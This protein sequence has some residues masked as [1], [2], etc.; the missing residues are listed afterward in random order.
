MLAVDIDDIV[1]WFMILRSTPTA[2]FRASS[3]ARSCKAW[4]TEAYQPRMKESGKVNKLKDY[5][6]PMWC[7][8]WSPIWR[9]LSA[10]LGEQGCAP[11][12]QSVSLSLLGAAASVSH[13]GATTATPKQDP[14]L[15]SCLEPNCFIPKHCETGNWK[16]MEKANCW[17]RSKVSY[18]DSTECLSV[19]IRLNMAKRTIKTERLPGA[20]KLG[21]G[22]FSSQHSHDFTCHNDQVASAAWQPY[23]G[24]RPARCRAFQCQNGYLRKPVSTFRTVD[25][26]YS[27][28]L[29]PIP[30][31]NQ[32]Y[33][34]WMFMIA[35]SSQ[36]SLSAVLFQPA[37]LLRRENSLNDKVPHAANT[38]LPK[39]T[40]TTR[41]SKGHRTRWFG[42]HTIPV[43][44]LKMRQ[45]WSK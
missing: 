2:L 8:S 9:I 45:I 23:C 39:C 38:P 32:L 13:N 16:K 24:K 34:L 29:E 21:H 5:E 41:G 35:C 28:F 33:S 18:E 31:L 26:L 27:F 36:S 37:F 7:F 20:G 17:K 14:S 22:S 1:Y 11:L 6:H 40:S 12:A 43:R 4:A 3:L 30:T 44:P 15:S 10:A 42:L 19:R 25:S